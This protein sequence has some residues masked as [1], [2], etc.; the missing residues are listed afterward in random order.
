MYKFKLDIR[1]SRSGNQETHALADY[2][3]LWGAKE[4]LI[5]KPLALKLATECNGCCSV[6]AV[7]AM[8]ILGQNDEAIANHLKVWIDLNQ[9]IG[10]L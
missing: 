2:L 1:C 6:V 4:R 3:P 8:D 10:N 5:S 7:R 9:A